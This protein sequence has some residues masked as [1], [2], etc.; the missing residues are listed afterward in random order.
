MH[1]LSVNESTVMPL[2]ATTPIG[3]GVPVANSSSS[4]R[5]ADKTPKTLAA[6][7]RWKIFSESGGQLIRLIDTT[8]PQ[9]ANWM[10]TVKLA[11]KREEQNLVAC[12]V[13]LF[14]GDLN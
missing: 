4:K 11:S 13:L 8:N 10:R 7:G 3:G 9:R 2:E 6:N 5:A 14:R 12:Q 1:T